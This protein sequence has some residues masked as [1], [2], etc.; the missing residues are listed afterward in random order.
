M[1]KKVEG[2]GQRVSQKVWARWKRRGYMMEMH[3]WRMMSN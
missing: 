3:G 1:K 2:S